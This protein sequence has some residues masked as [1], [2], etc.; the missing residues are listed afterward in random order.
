MYVTNNQNPSWNSSKKFKIVQ[1]NYVG[2]SSCELWKS[3]YSKMVATEKL[4]NQTLNSVAGPSRTPSKLLKVSIVLS[5]CIFYGA[6]VD[7]SRSSRYFDCLELRLEL[8]FILTSKIIFK[9]SLLSFDGSRTCS[10]IYIKSLGFFKEIHSFN[11]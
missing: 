11:I 8:S 7:L 6:V 3:N 2:R 5:Q 9:I 10:L 1:W 4:K